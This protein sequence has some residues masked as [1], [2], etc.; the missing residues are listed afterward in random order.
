MLRAVATG[1]IFTAAVGLWNALVVQ[2]LAGLGLPLEAAG[3]GTK[4]CALVLFGAWMVHDR[5]RP[6]LALRRPTD[7]RAV[8]NI[9][10]LVAMVLALNFDQALFLDPSLPLAI[11]AVVAATWEEFAFRGALMGLLLKHGRI[12]SAWISSVGFG[13]LHAVQPD[14]QSAALSVFMTTGLGLSLA[15]LR[16]ASGSLW[17][18]LAAH[19]I[20]NVSA[21]AAV[22]AYPAAQSPASWVPLLLGAYFLGYGAFL[23]SLL[24]ER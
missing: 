3:L 9:V 16:L 12:P 4:L 11:G 19:V 6:E 7:G 24:K 2:L 17:P 13:V 14:L 10:P 18:P 21:S 5:E 23:L 15:A 1:L 22:G 8:W 20:I